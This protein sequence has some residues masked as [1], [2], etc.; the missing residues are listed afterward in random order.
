MLLRG[1]AGNKTKNSTGDTKN[2]TE[3]KTLTLS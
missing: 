3:N 2:V 1:G